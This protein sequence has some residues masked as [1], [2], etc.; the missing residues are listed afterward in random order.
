MVKEAMSSNP[1]LQSV[2]GSFD[3]PSQNNSSPSMKNQKS[4]LYGGRKRNTSLT[5]QSPDLQTKRML[6]HHGNLLLDLNISANDNDERTNKDT[7]QFSLSDDLIGSNHAEKTLREKFLN[8]NEIDKESLLRESISEEKL[9]LVKKPL[10]PVYIDDEKENRDLL[11]M[12]SKGKEEED[13][14]ENL[15]NLIDSNINM[16]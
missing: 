8:D 4:V 11:L 16:G 2:Y 9:G 6:S 12:R 10:A 13:E 5:Q 14:D 7:N 3:S 15:I 1:M